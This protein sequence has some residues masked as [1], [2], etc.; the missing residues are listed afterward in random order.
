MKNGAFLKVLGYFKPLIVAIFELESSLS[1]KW[2]SSAHQR[3]YCAS[4]GIPKNPEFFDHHIDLFYQWQKKRMSFWVERGVFGTLA[5]KRSGEVLELACG[6]GFNTCNF[7]SGLVKNV[8][9]CDF[10]ENAISTARRKNQAP[11][12][13]FVLADIR[14]SMPEGIYDNIVWDA[15]IEHFTPAEISDIMSNIK[16]RLKPEG[17][18]SGYTIVENASGKALEQHEYEFKDM[19]DLKSFLAPSFKNVVVFETIHPKRHNLYFWASDGVI[20]FSESWKHW[21]KCEK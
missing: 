15:A 11:N 17:I 9:A 8:V 5:L 18:L 16:K 12:V 13:K 14:T 2:A 3:L 10:D 1:R 4:W 20:P 6:D 21:I 7:Y 19:A